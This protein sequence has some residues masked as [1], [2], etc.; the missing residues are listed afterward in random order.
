[1]RLFEQG[2]LLLRATWHQREA[3]KCAASKCSNFANRRRTDCGGSSRAFTNN[4]SNGGPMTAYEACILFF[5]AAVVPAGVG[6][7]VCVV[8]RKEEATHCALN[9]LRNVAPEHALKNFAPQRAPE[10]EVCHEPNKPD[11]PYQPN[12]PNKHN[13]PNKFNK[14]EQ[15]PNSDYVFHLCSEARR[16]L[17][18]ADCSKYVGDNGDSD[19]VGDSDDG[20]DDKG[21]GDSDDGD[22]QED[23]IEAACAAALQCSAAACAYF[24]YKL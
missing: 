7:G 16:L 9:A 21:S 4:S 5:S 6:I 22:R 18:A 13:K 20:N 17:D 19:D 10:P 15:E 2:K 14:P 11:Q 23:Q 1:M 3:S 8:L 12:K 24:A